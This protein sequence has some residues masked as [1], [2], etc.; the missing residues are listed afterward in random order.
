MVYDHI[1]CELA[2]CGADCLETEIS[3]GSN[4]RTTLLLCRTVDRP[5]SIC[6]FT[7]FA[8]YRFAERVILRQNIGHAANVGPELSTHDGS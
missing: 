3:S 2:Q 6:F 4:A 1:Y 7:V 8:H 5:V